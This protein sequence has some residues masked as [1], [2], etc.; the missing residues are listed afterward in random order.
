MDWSA[1][2]IG[3]RVGGHRGSS[4]DAPENTM[5]AFERS[6]SDGA[7]YVETDV[8]RTADGELVL[9]HDAMVDR[10]TNGHGRISRLTSGDL[11]KLDA[12]SRY[13]QFFRGEGIPTL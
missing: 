3:L 8:R 4:A 1:R 10:T 13:D 12:G 11:Q 6:L 5:A 7:D 2:S 9:I